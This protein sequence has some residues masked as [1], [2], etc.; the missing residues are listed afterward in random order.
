[1]MPAAGPGFEEMPGHLQ[2][3]VLQ[4]LAESGDGASLARC[5]ASSR[6]LR[7][8]SRS[9]SLWRV[10]CEAADAF[11][12]LPGP[13]GALSDA[14]GAA[15]RD[16]AG[17]VASG[18]A[19]FRLRRTPPRSASLWSRP[20]SYRE[21]YH[22]PDGTTAF[23]GQGRGG[24][25]WQGGGHGVIAS[26]A[27]AFAS[28]EVTRIVLTP[29]AYFGDV[30]AYAA[31]PDPFRKQEA[32]EMLRQWALSLDRSHFR[33][34]DGSSGVPA[35]TARPN[36]GTRGTRLLVR[37]VAHVAAR[38]LPAFL[39]SASPVWQKDCAL[40][41]L[42]T[43]GKVYNPY[44]GNL[45]A[46]ILI[47]AG[48][49][50]ALLKLVKPGDGRNG[51][52]VRVRALWTIREV[53]DCKDGEV[54]RAGLRQLATA[55]FRA[56]FSDYLARG[57]S[58]VLIE[59]LSHMKSMLDE[60]A[61]DEQSAECRDGPHGSPGDYP[62]S[63]LQLIKVQR[64]GG[65]DARDRRYVPESS[66]YRKTLEAF[67]NAFYQ[68][69]TEIDYDKHAGA[70]QALAAEAVPVLADLVPV[71]GEL[72]ISPFKA[73]VVVG[74]S[75]AVGLTLGAVPAPFMAAVCSS[76]AGTVA[77][78]KRTGESLF[79][80]AQDRLRVDLAC[81]EVAL[82]A[83]T[84]AL[85]ERLDAAGRRRLRLCRAAEERT[86][87]YEDIGPPPTRHPPGGPAVGR[88]DDEE[89][90]ASRARALCVALDVPLPPHTMEELSELAEH[91]VACLQGCR[92]PAILD[93]HV[94]VVLLKNM[95][96]LV[97]RS[98]V[99][100]SALVAQDAVSCLLDVLFD[101]ADVL[102]FGIYE[103]PEL[104]GELMQHGTQDELASAD[105]F[106]RDR[107][108]DESV[109]RVLGLYQDRIRVA[110]EHVVEHPG[111]AGSWGAH[112]LESIDFAIS[113]I[114]TLASALAR[115]RLHVTS[116][117]FP[118]SLDVA[119][120]LETLLDLDAAV[121][122]VDATLQLQGA[123]ILDPGAESDNALPE[124]LADLDEDIR[125]AITNLRQC[126]WVMDARDSESRPSLTW[127]MGHRKSHRLWALI[128]EEP[129]E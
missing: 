34:S 55:G 113:V 98:G 24:G 106:A 26:F 21:A 51:R 93:Y 103:A 30:L 75:A 19:S 22:S 71:M 123:G 14:E 82:Q 62:R 116:P 57:E 70:M 112:T 43:L 121:E 114:S 109:L 102:Q 69:F 12:P 100:R 66:E 3:R 72:C 2:V 79:A 15:G 54:V 120:V 37:T 80:K 1:M 91:F 99:L 4:A 44:G 118:E 52:R 108:P 105:F 13:A 31:S 88:D 68:A 115:G 56:V 76:L 59:E 58:G 95:G 92:F 127:A 33:H 87:A 53:L 117:D 17:D 16:W 78:R 90:G 124:I 48:I 27:A 122:Q 74:G 38:E 39:E 7:R 128:A 63:L 28:G 61:G 5:G 126:A 96:A 20:P 29:E 25:G 86:A 104:L 10:A 84:D 110:A 8:L 77:T 9:E 49:I 65:E 64:S 36:L 23:T 42:D 85:N 50:R 40:D 81:L 41:L 11:R 125:D 18:E 46:L 107:A 89:Q 129:P 73:I 83:L 94:D 111:D 60:F 47:Q 101:H 67:V 45:L 6:S 119:D 97:A 32:F 35:P